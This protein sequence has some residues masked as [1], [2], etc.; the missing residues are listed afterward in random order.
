MESPAKPQKG[1]KPP[2]KTSGF[3]QGFAKQ[4]G[5]LLVNNIDQVRGPFTS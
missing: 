3:K 5:F 2:N 1:G 4:A